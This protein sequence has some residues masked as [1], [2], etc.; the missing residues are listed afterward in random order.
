MKKFIVVL[1]FGI[2]V[3]GFW[4]VVAGGGRACCALS[5]QRSVLSA[6]F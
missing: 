6:Q 1:G 2:L 4:L 5:T 3:L